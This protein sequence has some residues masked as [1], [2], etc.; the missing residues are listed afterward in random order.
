MRH[1][2]GTEPPAGRLRID[3]DPMREGLHR[4]PALGHR[5]AK[6]LVHTGSPSRPIDTLRRTLATAR[7]EIRPSSACRRGTSPKAP[8]VR[9]ERPASVPKRPL[10]TAIRVDPLQGADMAVSPI[11][12]TAISTPWSGSSDSPPTEAGQGTSDGDG[13]GRGGARGGGGAGRRGAG[14]AGAGRGGARGGVTGEPI[15]GVRIP[16]PTIPGRAESV[17]LK[18]K[19]ACISRSGCG[20][21]VGR[22]AGVTPDRPE[23][24]W[25]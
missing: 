13:A 16:L 1:P 19:W 18:A 2:P 11:P 22:A 23:T 9:R 5:H 14:G 15:G 12:D 8:E 4:L 7:V 21:T 10:Q 24:R 20:I 17:A 25:G 6:H 3:P